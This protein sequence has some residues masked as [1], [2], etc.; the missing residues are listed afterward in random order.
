M[1]FQNYALWP[2]IAVRANIALRLKLRKLAAAT[3]AERVA[4]VWTR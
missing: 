4:A 3:I 1:V 2:H